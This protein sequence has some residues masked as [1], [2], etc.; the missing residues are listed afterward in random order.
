M[1]APRLPTDLQPPRMDALARLAVFLALEGRRA[2]V[3]GGNAQAA[4]KAEL[5]SAA[6]ANVEVFAEAPADELVG[7]A[8]NP[9]RGAVTINRRRVAADDFAGAAVAVGAFADHGDAP[10][11][12]PPA[13]PRR[14]PV[15]LIHQP[16]FFDFAFAAIVNPSPLLLD[17]P[18]D[19]PAP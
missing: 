15:N 16:A 14:L 10:Q 7:L 9:P 8:Q 5:L 19:R 13:R 18:T 4:W 2:V 12:A 11:F 1:T 3:A 17:L 6:G